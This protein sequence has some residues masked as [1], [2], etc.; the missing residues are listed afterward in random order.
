MKHK[1]KAW[2]LFLALFCCFSI[3]VAYAEKIV[4]LS[5]SDVT[6]ALD[7][8][9]LER[10]ILLK[11]KE[12]FDSIS[13]LPM[14][15]RF[16]TNPDPS[17][18]YWY[19]LNVK[20]LNNETI[21][22]IIVSYFYSVDEIDIIVR[23]ANGQFQLQQFRDTMSVYDRLIQHKQPSFTLKIN[24]G[25]TRTI[26]FRLKNESTY[27]YNFGIF[28]HFHFFENYF[29][30]YL[31]LGLFYG[32]MLFILIYSIF[33]YL[34]FRDSVVLIYIIFI[35]S[36]TIHMLFRDGNGLYLL[37]N[38]AEY[39][40]LIKNLS[41]ASISV[42]ILIYTVQFLKIKRSELIFKLVVFYIVARIL[43]ALY[44]MGNTSLIT[45]NFEL[46]AILISTFLSI[47]AFIKGDVDAKYMVVGFL[48]LSISYFV[49][50][51]S[52]MGLSWLGSIG[53]FILYFGMA[54]ESIF[55]ALALTERFKRI[56]LDNYKKDLMNHEL[57]QTVAIRTDLI[58][59]Q[60]KILEEQSSELNSFLYSASHDLK[61]P[62]KTIEGLI[63]LG[64]KD[65]QVNHSQIYTLIK[66]KLTTLEENI[67]DLNSVTLIKNNGKELGLID[68]EKIYLKT[69]EKFQ[70]Q[71]EKGNIKLNFICEINTP[72]Q[73]D[74]LPIKTIFHHIIG[75]AIKFID[76][77]KASYITITVGRE[78]G[79]GY[80]LMFEDN[81]VGIKESI[82]PSIF[83]M[84]YR[85]NEKSR[86]DT[87][88][89]L[90]IVSLAVKKLS[91]T[92]EV[93]SKFGIGTKFIINFP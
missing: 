93:E 73:G 32:F 89:G 19:R 91:G 87:G 74:L 75:N 92:I 64:L 51:L 9:S 12:N 11:G 37:P 61:G 17:S 48:V 79:K 15:T 59:M 58:T 60:N 4:L 14:E 7:S 42:F 50:Y 85:G 23:D 82:L 16:M 57:E 62:I 77:S 65:P 25:E 52:V 2:F 81:G 30:E 24:S 5:D 3:N 55:T 68:F 90:Y 70:T 49:F 45:F 34:F 69:I 39:V 6:Y 27:E 36:Q 40:D 47:R 63:N 21:D 54:G 38:Y 72:M 78:E 33:N 41:R 18:E 10:I 84:F 67:S 35:L 46:F 26:Y 56:R 29:I 31:L 66:E 88:L 76:S 22:W 53:F 28:S 8:N 44:M 80:K 1:I 83:K 20:N 86:N 13:I 43:Y 71:I